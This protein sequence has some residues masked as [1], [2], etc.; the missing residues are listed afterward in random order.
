MICIVNGGEK[1]RGGEIFRRNEEARGKVSVN[2]STAS[3]C[4]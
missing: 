2:N 4:G 1:G 3:S